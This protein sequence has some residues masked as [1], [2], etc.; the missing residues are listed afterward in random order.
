MRR[1]DLVKV[2]L[3]LAA[4]PA[5][6]PLC[7]AYVL[8]Q[9]SEPGGPEDGPEPMRPAGAAPAPAESPTSAPAARP[10]RPSGSGAAPSF[11]P[12]PPLAPFEI[13]TGPV[14]NNIVGLN[15]ARLHQ[16]NYIWATSDVVNANGGDWGYITVV[17]TIEDREAR[18][19]EYNL[20]LFLDRCFEFHVQPIVR[21]GTKFAAKKEPVVPGQPAPKPNPQ[22]AEG[23]WVRPDWDEPLKWR[24]FFETARWPTRHAWVVVGN[25]PNLG[26]EWGGA[27]DPVSYARYLDH[28]LDVFE[29]APRFDVVSGALDISN[30]TVMPVMQDALEFLDGM[31]EAVP[32]IFERLPAWA[33][34]P[35]KVVSAGRGVRYTH[36]AYEAEFDRIGREMPVLITEAGH[37]ETGD[38]QEIARFYEEAFRAWMADPKVVAATPLFWHPDRNDFWMFELD[39]RGAFVHKSPTYELLRRLPRVAGSPEFTVQMENVA[40]TTP[41]ETFVAEEPDPADEA[42]GETSAAGERP[43]ARASRG[44]VGEA[45]DGDLEAAERGPALAPSG[46]GRTGQSGSVADPARATGA[47]ARTVAPARGPGSQA[48]QVANTDGQ[49]AR[50]RMAPS[51]ESEAILVLPDGAV[52][53]ALG[54]ERELGDESW[55]RVRA[56]DGEEGWIAS[57]LLAPTANDE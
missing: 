40:R 57:E 36:R 47:T 1:R 8:A 3:G 48:L 17:W 28:F 46:A 30:S 29:E 32:R 19:A 4:A 9:E 45:D 27:V 44:G 42:E 25:E 22:G 53:Q 24:T 38:E 43:G 2:L 37:L 7:E 41:F 14:P 26:R 49:G 34:N 52:V 50:L 55:R 20:Q 15:V 56:P 18:M 35:Y 33:S 51:R 13:A 23:S 21:V 39:K 6:L 31:G 16:P 10:T 54:P 12:P 5:L 11:A